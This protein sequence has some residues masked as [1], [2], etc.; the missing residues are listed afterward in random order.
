MKITF[1]DGSKKDFPQGTTVLAIAKSI[2]EGLARNALAGKVEGEV[3]DLSYG[4]QQDSTIQILTARDEDGLFVLRHSCAHLLAHAVQRLY[5]KALPTIGPVIENGFYYDFADLAIKEEDLPAIEQEMKKIIKEKIPVERVEHAS[6]KEALEKYKKNKFKVELIKEFDEGSSTYIQGDFHDLCRGPHVPNT[7]LFEGFKL[8]KLAGAYWRGDAKREQLTRIY[9]T[10]FATK[11]ELNAYLELLKEAEKRNHQ[12]IG[13]AMELFTHFPDVG[14]GLPIWLPKG[15]IIRRAVEAFALETEEAAGYVRVTTPHLAK[16][17]LFLRS[18]HLPYYEETMYPKMKMDDGEYYLKAMNCPLHHLI[19]SHTSRSYRELPL[20]VAEYG[21]C[22][23]NE[24]SGTLS[25]LLRVRMLSMNDAHIYCTK[26]QIAKEVA[27]TL[28]M[29]EKYF[30]V[31]G[32]QDYWFR[33]SLG[34]RSNTEKYIDD[35]KNWAYTEDVLRRVLEDLKLPFTEEQDEAAFYGPKIDIQF[36]NVYGREESMSTVQLDFAAKERFDLT[37]MDDSGTKNPNVYV[38]HRAP[39]ST[40]ERFMAFLI[41]HYAGKFPLWL[42]PEQ[43]R[44]I[45]IADR[46]EVYAAEVAEKMKDVG[47][48]VTV[49][50]RAETTNR[51]I[52]EA[53]LSHVNYILVI[54]DKELTNGTVNV[55]TRDNVVHGEQKVAECIKKLAT[56]VAT[57][58]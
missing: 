29:I 13:E 27:A 34:D 19:Y 25:G 41:E 38:I 48:R 42:A 49:D 33:L 12:K 2:S 44:I 9:G 18:G 39:L 57:K 54:G 4:V 1:P 37:Y 21:T 46:Q 28:Q 15:E 20:R 40:H 30:K 17:E 5:P 36:K 56:E 10:C 45:I 51:K 58:A 6:K 8:L 22:Y 11:K 32:F 43:A 14:K 35:P 16:K 3:K 47:L 50:T 23:R 26:E 7:K 52:R 55:R 53:Q 31:F 24:L